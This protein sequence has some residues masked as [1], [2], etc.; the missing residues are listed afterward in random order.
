MAVK[1]VIWQDFEGGWAT[2]LKVGIKNSSAYTQSLDFRK[3]PSQISVL[4][5]PVREDNGVVNDLIQ[6]E[7]MINN[8]TI[9]A[10]GSKG[11]FYS[12]TTSGVWSVEGTLSP[13]YF[14]IDY[15]Q[16]Q[17]SIYIC[18][19]KNVSM[20]N[21]ISKTPFLA[22]DFF[23]A[24]LSTYN[25]TANAGFNVNCDQENS[26]LK[27]AILVAASPLS[28]D[29][30]QRR[31]FQTD[32]EPLIKI[33]VN[34]TAKGTGNWTLTLHD[35]LNNVLGTVTIANAS[36]VIG[37]NYF[38]FSTQVRASV[39]PAAQTYHVHV[40]STVADGSVSSTVLN[41]LSTCDFQVWADRMVIPTNGMHPMANFLQYE[42]IGNERYLSVW[43]P[44]G[45]PAPSNSEWQRHRLIFPPF[46]QVCGLAVLN[47]YIAIACEKITTGNGQP[48]EGIIFWWDGLSP[49]YNFFTKIPEG[50]PYGIQE[51]QNSVYYEAGGAWYGIA[52]ANSLPVKLRTLPSS[53]G[54]YSGVTGNTIVY[55]YASTVRKDILLS[56]WPSTTTS[57]TLPYGVYS[58]G[59]V[60]KNYPQSFGYNY[61]ISTGDQFNTGGNLTIGMVKNFGDTLHTSWYNGTNYGIDVVNN[62][63]K[64]ASYSTW[65]SLIFDGGYVAKEKTANYIE[66]QWLPLPAGATI[67]LKYQIDRSGTWTSSPAYSATN[68]WNNGQDGATYARFTVTNPLGQNG[69][70]FNEFQ[71]AIDINCNITVT[72]PPIIIMASLVFDDNSG[73]QLQ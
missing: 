48:Q 57:I 28:E 7:V 6:N 36:L 72:Q 58:W 62:S 69:G 71:M 20:Y 67:T 11:N 5:Q 37:W 27:T 4:P 49:S 26:P 25:N 54:E 34:V 51:Y 59:A 2:D 13:G 60:D 41:D 39:A 23:A 30:N 22:P 3:S 61:L 43:E 16:D 53:Q 32:I 45:D 47:E 38:N 21:P 63:S 50:S 19:A 10:L 35:G 14:G 44:L 64:P 18:G 9:Y 66:C 33:G 70:R 68:L 73:E 46:Y 42:C 31:F 65:N 52:G 55:P 8:G 29:N 40:T 56:A 15:R 1:A 24:S 17:D 12:R